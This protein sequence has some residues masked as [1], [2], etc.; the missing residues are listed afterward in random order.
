M[1]EE[2]EGKNKV[3]KKEKISFGEHSKKIKMRRT[4][5]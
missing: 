3:K 5:W 4:W 1:Y 2:R